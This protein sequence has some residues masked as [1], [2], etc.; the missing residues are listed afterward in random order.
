M[1]QT[2]PHP[3]HW[4]DLTMAAPRKPARAVAVRWQ[5]SNDWTV[6]DPA[7]PDGREQIAHWERNPDYVYAEAHYDG[8]EWQ[9]VSVKPGGQCG[10]RP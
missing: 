6:A 10:F 1:V 9:L 8:E 5:G 3:P 7:T 2:I 4:T